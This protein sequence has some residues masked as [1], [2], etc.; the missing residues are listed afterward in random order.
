MKIIRRVNPHDIVIKYSDGMCEHRVQ[1]KL[2][3]KEDYIE[4]LR[5]ALN[6]VRAGM[7]DVTVIQ[8]RE[9]L[10]SHSELRH[11]AAHLGRHATD[12]EVLEQVHNS[13]RLPQNP[14][15]MKL[16]TSVG[17]HIATLWA[18]AT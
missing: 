16:L 14:N 15:L 13:T 8:Y 18:V 4:A 9:T 3:F 2:N 17:T 11:A 5:S 1:T 7:Q 12:E 6:L 10:H